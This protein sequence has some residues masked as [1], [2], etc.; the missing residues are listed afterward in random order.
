MTLE[1]CVGQ[2]GAC[3]FFVPDERDEAHA[4][5]K[6]RPGNQVQV[7]FYISFSYSTLTLRTHNGIWPVQL[8]RSRNVKRGNRP[9]VKDKRSPGTFK[10][11]FKERSG[12]EEY[13][14]RG[15]R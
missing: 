6:Q 5:I 3:P 2:G 7:L 11:L 15:H 4:P 10:E 12:E 8:D 1:D 9:Y 14:S 13:Q